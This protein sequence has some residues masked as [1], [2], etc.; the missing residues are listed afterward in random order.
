MPNPPQWTAPNR[1]RLQEL[2]A[3]EPEDPSP[4]RHGRGLY[5]T[6]PSGLAYLRVS[7]GIGIVSPHAGPKGQCVQSAAAYFQSEAT[8]H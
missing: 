3:E 1:G 2:K 4:Q 6:R 5:D 7:F 8:C